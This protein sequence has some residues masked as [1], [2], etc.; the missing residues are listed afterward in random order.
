VYVATIKAIDG[1]AGGSA[2]HVSTCSA[3]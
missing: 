1:T 3:A 2:C